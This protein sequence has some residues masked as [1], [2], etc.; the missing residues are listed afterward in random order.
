MA[1]RARP[2]EPKVLAFDG[3]ELTLLVGDRI[4]RGAVERRGS[5]LLVHHRGLVWAFDEGG[6]AARDHAVA[7]PSELV[8]PMTGTVVQV[9]AADGQAVESGAPLVIVEAMKMEH[10]IVAPAK[11]KVAR[12]HVKSGDRVDVGAKLVSLELDDVP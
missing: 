8:A 1:D 2:P 3:V 10:R 7:A 4:V 5:R 11:A 6:A 9:L 12:I